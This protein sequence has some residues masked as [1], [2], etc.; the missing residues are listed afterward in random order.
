VTSPYRQLPLGEE[1]IHVVERE[2][3]DARVHGELA[4]ETHLYRSRPIGS[5]NS[6]NPK[7][8]T[9]RAARANAAARA[10][11]PYLGDE[12]GGGA[13]GGR[14][15][16]GDRGRVVALGVEE[17]GDRLVGGAGEGV[18][19]VELELVGIG[20]LLPQLPLLRR[21]DHG[22]AAAPA[23]TRGLEIEAQASGGTRQ[24]ARPV[25]FIRRGKPPLL[26]RSATASTSFVWL[27]DGL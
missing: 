25:R 27:G 22:A 9:E 23:L 13:A 7:Q 1:A 12:G 16:G 14:G 18:L 15:R 26:R 17:T 24:E 8:R 20:V 5:G 11:T 4:A 2:V 3:G 10:G 21:H 6:G 19:E